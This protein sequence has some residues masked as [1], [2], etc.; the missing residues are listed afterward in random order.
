MV[1][2][3]NAKIEAG[4]VAFAV[5]HVD[6]DGG[7][8]HSQGMGHPG[9]TLADQGV[10]IQVVANV[11]GQETEILRFDCLD[12]VPSYTYGPEKEDVLILMDPT[13]AGNPIGW[14]VAQIGA[15]LPDMIRRAGYEAIADQVDNN[16][17]S[18]MVSEVE[19]LARDLGSKTRNT[20]THNRGTQVI[21]AG[22]IRFGLEMRTVGPDG[23]PAIHVLGDVAGQEIELLAFDC[24]RIFPHYHYGPRA[25]NER[26]YH[27]TTVTTDSLE[28]TLNQFKEGK[29]PDMIERAGYPTLVQQMDRDLIARTVP[30]VEATIKQ[31]S[32]DDPR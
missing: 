9:R 25:K 16:L 17:V 26:I 2:I 27:D 18:Q 6:L 30:Q 13:T 4:V 12:N 31:M 1:A 5:S 24:F 29:L 14:S 28:W 32:Q 15:H 3:G 23:G 7:A 21:E 20:V 10:R 19:E 11:D 22:N 8:P